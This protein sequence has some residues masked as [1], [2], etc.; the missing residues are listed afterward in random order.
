MAKIT[1]TT[2]RQPWVG[3]K[4]RAKGDVIDVSAD[5]AKALAGAG[6]AEVEA[7]KRAARKVA[8]DE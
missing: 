6:F 1:I 2:D 3:G 7:P 4:P 5:D 8:D